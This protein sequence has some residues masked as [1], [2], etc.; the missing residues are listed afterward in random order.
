MP[1]GYRVAGRVLELVCPAGLEVTAR[2]AAVRVAEDRIRAHVPERVR[3]VFV[4]D[5]AEEGWLSPACLS[6][7]ARVRRLC[8]SLVIPVE[9]VAGPAVVRE[10][11]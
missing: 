3:L 4:A 9:A 10:A 2:A 6:V 5:R 11:A 8:E 7:L 1:I